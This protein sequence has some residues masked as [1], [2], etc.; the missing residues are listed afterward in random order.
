MLPHEKDNTET[1]H[2][3]WKTVLT[4]AP[5]RSPA[6][7]P[8]TSLLQKPTL[9]GFFKRAAAVLGANTEHPLV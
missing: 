4:K 6:I 2:E 1:K 5:C 9:P 7:V 3:P 8:V